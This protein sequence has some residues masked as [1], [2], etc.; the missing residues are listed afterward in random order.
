MVAITGEVVAVSL[1]MVQTQPEY[2]MPQAQN[3]AEIEGL[4][5]DFTQALS[6]IKVE[7]AER[8]D[9]LID[10]ISNL[11]AN[12]P[13]DAMMLKYELIN[14]ELQ[15]TLHAKLIS[16]ATEIPNKLVEVK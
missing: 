11:D 9:T 4:G 3:M 12:N 7:S 13:G 14:V 5:D 8:S 10:R 1:D 16:K 15:N 2:T 6:E